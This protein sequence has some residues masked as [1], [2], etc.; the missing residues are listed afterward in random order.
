M[1][2]KHLR[3]HNLGVTLE[4]PEEAIA[5]YE[6]CVALKDKDLTKTCKAEVQ[7]VL[8]PGTEMKGLLGGILNELQGK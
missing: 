4:R 6:E 3:L 5:T 8:E 7:S 1:I 2:R